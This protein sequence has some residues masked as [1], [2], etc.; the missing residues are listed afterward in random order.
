M[1][2]DGVDR[3]ADEYRIA[4][5]QLVISIAE[6]M[7]VIVRHQTNPKTE[8]HG[9]GDQA[10]AKH[11]FLFSEDIVGDITMLFITMELNSM[12]SPSEIARRIDQAPS[13][14]RGT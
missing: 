3:V 1:S 11:S 7:N 10:F 13:P 8:H 5:A 4:E 6:R 12:L 2:A 9:A 14:T